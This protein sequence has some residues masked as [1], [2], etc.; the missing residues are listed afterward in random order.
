M[1]KTSSYEKNFGNAYLRFSSVFLAIILISFPVA[2]GQKTKAGQKE[3]KWNGFVGHYGFVVD[4]PLG[5][6]SEAG[7][8]DPEGKLE[9]IQFWPKGHCSGQD[10]KSCAV[11]DGWFNLIVMPKTIISRYNK[12]DTFDAFFSMIQKESMSSGEQPVSLNAENTRLK[13]RTLILK[14]PNGPFTALTFLEGKKMYYRFSY[15]KGNKLMKHVIASLA[16]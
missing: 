12:A 3:S 15:D 16:E 14:K 13:G 7:F 1:K 4:Y 8:S 11:N 6:T 5:F 10:E 2:A 9:V